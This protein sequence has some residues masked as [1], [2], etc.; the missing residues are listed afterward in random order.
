MNPVGNRLHAG[1]TARQ[2]AE[3]FERGRREMVGLAVAG[4]QQKVHHVVGNLV[5]RHFGC[6]HVGCV[7]RS[8]HQRAV[9]DRQRAGLGLQAQEAVAGRKLGIGAAGRERL[10]RQLLS[11]HGLARA[12]RGVDLEH[13]VADRVELVLQPAVDLKQ[14]AARQ[15]RNRTGGDGEGFDHGGP[16]L[17]AAR[18]APLA[19]ATIESARSKATN[20]R[21]RTACVGQ[22]RARQRRRRRTTTAAAG[23]VRCARRGAI[24]TLGACSHCIKEKPP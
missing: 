11:Q 17:Q 1:V 7:E 4:R 20:R 22:D 12:Y 19:D 23:P 18:L 3:Q 14:G 13:E 16:A 2:G 10:D 8:L 21:T 15:R 9:V 6:G 24:R 5:H